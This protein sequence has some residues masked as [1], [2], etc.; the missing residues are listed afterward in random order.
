[1]IKHT[2]RFVPLLAA[3]LC[4]TV[5]A[6]DE[7]TFSAYTQLSSCNAWVQHC[8]DDSVQDSNTARDYKIKAKDVLRLVIDSLFPVD[9]RVR[10]FSNDVKLSPSH[11]NAGPF[12]IKLGISYDGT[13]FLLRQQDGYTGFSLRGA[14]VDI[15]D[16]KPFAQIR[17]ELQW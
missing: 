9:A 5:Q 10:Y 6:S 17:F 1:M 11:S 14:P 15:D 12:Q 13:Q 16:S 2:L 7:L 3:G 4:S 8:V